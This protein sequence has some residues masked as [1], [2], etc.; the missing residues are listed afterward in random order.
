M[1]TCFGLGCKKPNPIMN[2][3]MELRVRVWNPPF[4]VGFMVKFQVIELGFRTNPNKSLC[5]VCVWVM[6]HIRVV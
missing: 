6:T 1:D 5:L 4:E 2:F 3:C